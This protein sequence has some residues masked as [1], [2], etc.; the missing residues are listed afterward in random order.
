MQKGKERKTLLSAG[1]ADRASLSPA[2][3]RPINPGIARPASRLSGS[4][5]WSALACPRWPR[6]LWIR[7]LQLGILGGAGQHQGSVRGG[8]HTSSAVTH[9]CQ[10][11]AQSSS[12]SYLP[13]LLGLLLGRPSTSLGVFAADK[14]PPGTF[15]IW[16]ESCHRVRDFGAAVALDLNHHLKLCCPREEFLFPI[17]YVQ[18]A[19]VMS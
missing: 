6:D 17:R 9:P 18:Q 19:V 2:S 15:R 14:L 13:L 10:G 11:T 3:G 1:C 7:N 5:I 12:R 16:D 8:R 4:M